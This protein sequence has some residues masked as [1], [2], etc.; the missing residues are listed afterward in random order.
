MESYVLVFTVLSIPYVYCNLRGGLIDQDKEDCVALR[1]AGTVGVK[2]PV[3][4]ELFWI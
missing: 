1:Y 4:L 3:P 2:I